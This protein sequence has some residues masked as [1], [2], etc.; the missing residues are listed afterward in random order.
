MKKN[1]NETL[2]RFAVEGIPLITSIA[3][4]LDL[5]AILSKYIHSYGNEKIPV[6]DALMILL[7]IYVI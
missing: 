5:A 6:M 7:C 1:N 4:R 2:R 3:Q